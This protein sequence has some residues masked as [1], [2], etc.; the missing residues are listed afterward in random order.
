MLP[1]RRSLP[2]RFFARDTVTVAREL[3]GCTLWAAAGGRTC[4]G[5]IVESEAYLD[6]RDPA[7]HAAR[8]RTERNAVMFGP[9][10]VVYIYLIYGLHYCLNLVAEAEGRAGAVLVRALE[11]LVGLEFMRER[12]G[13]ARDAGL[14]AGPGRL[15]RALGIDLAWNGLPLGDRTS[16]PVQPDR[17]VRVW[18]AAGRAPAR[19]TAGP[20]VGIRHAA[21]R[22]F[23]FCDADSASL[24]R[25]PVT[26][27]F[28][29]IRSE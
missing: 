25:R 6:E 11:P 19:L 14:C 3:I 28:D 8:G 4:A 9:A 23:R 1:P 17:D 29:R 27:G 7:S 16:R 24:S 13:S 22:P 15:C 21:A 18:V 10:A 2:R 26:E 20:R 5:R 12:C